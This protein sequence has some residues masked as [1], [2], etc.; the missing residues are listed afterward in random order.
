[1]PSR[2]PPM[3]HQRAAR[4]TDDEKPDHATDKTPAYRR[5]G[6]PQL[7]DIP[8]DARRHHPRRDPPGQRLLEEL[9]HCL[10][11]A[12][13][14]PVQRGVARA[15]TS[16]TCTGPK[17]LESSDLYPLLATKTSPSPTVRQPS[18]CGRRYP[19]ASG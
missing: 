9:P 11:H 8:P 17:Y 12:H 3:T 5:R 14:L 7:H 15:K 6:Q 19:P 18:I 10:F 1:M 16:V 4:A 13:Y 2:L